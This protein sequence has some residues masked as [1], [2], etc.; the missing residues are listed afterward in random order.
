MDLY[1]V[2]NIEGTRLGLVSGSTVRAK[3]IAKDVGAGLKGLVGGKIGSYD[4]LL[5]ESRA[6]AVQ[7]MTA[8]AE[9]L[10][11]NAVIGVR[12]VTSEI[13]AGAAEILVYGTAIRA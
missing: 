8:E 11:A 12:F 6:E 10:G 2:E 9:S 3:N 7:K 4:K 13:A 5:Q 1:T